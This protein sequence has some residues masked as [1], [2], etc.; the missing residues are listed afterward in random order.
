[1][2][3]GC[4]GAGGAAVLAAAALPVAVHAMACG[5]AGETSGLRVYDGTGASSGAAAGDAD[6][7]AG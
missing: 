4:M 7:E 3:E 1:M 6:L 5:G 2:A